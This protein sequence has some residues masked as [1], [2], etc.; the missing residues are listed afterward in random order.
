MGNGG[1]PYFLRVLH[2]RNQ[3]HP[4]RQPL[5][6]K[7]EDLLSLPVVT[8]YTSFGY[9]VMLEDADAEMLEGVLQKM[10]LKKGLAIMICSPGGDGLAAERMINVCRSYSGTGK[11]V[12]IVAGK[13]KSAATMLCF[14]ASKILMGPNSELGPIDPQLTIRERGRVKRFSVYNVIHSYET[15]FRA[16]VRTKGNLEPF[17]LQLENYDEREIEE[18]RSAMSLSADIAVRS[19]AK[20][21]MRGQSERQIRR[22]IAAFLTPEQT[23]THGRP[24]YREEALRCRL[25]ADEMSPDLLDPVWELHVRTSGFVSSFAAKCIETKEYSFYAS[26]PPDSQEEDADDETN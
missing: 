20:G 24:I 2:E 17:L 11:F 25:V 15:L 5:F 3:A 12:A 7:I 8:C 10:D 18:M 14:G 4:T 13:A 26:P 23:K 21:M 9:P 16:A 19:L 1:D 6:A 22:R